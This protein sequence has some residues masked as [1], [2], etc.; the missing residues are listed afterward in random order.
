MLACRFA[1]HPGAF[2]L[3]QSHEPSTAQAAWAAGHSEHPPDEAPAPLQVDVMCLLSLYQTDCH[4]LTQR[5]CTT[6]AAPGRWVVEAATK[7]AMC[8]QC[9]RALPT[10]CMRSRAPSIG[11]CG[12]A[13][14]S[15]S[16][17][18]GSWH[19][20]HSCR[21]GGCLGRAAPQQQ[22][23]SLGLSR[24]LSRN[25]CRLNVVHDTD[26]GDITALYATF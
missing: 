22:Q 17:V 24:V 7:L 26:V 3:H 12:A 21:G 4:S 5:S 1:V 10:L 11:I 25:N 23:Q 8:A 16:Q 19:A 18:P 9:S 20:V 14:I 2:L 6:A 13:P 15:R